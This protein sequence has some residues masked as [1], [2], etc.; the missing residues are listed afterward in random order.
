MTPS[1]ELSHHARCRSAWLE[2]AIASLATDAHAGAVILC[3][4]LGRGQFDAWSD[5]DLIVAFDDEVAAD[6]IAGRLEWVASFGDVL[7]RRD[8]PANGPVC[9]GQ[10]S[11]LYFVGSPIPLY[12]DWYV[13]PLSMVTGVPHTAKVVLARRPVPLD[14]SIDLFGYERP[15]AQIPTDPQMLW[16]LQNSDRFAMIP[17]AAKYIGRARV[18]TAAFM[19]EKIGAQLETGTKEALLAACR[20]R[21]RTVGG[22]KPERTRAAVAMMLDFVERWDES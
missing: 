14:D 18:D 9:G 12:V 21:L 17:I 13:W 10:V 8:K 5:V 4:S 16:E 19:L 6:R 22:D 3:G 11:A 2:A 1:E 7:D 20:E 15:A